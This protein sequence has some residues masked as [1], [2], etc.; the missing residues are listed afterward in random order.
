M[1]LVAG[2]EHK[3]LVVSFSL[4][5]EFS[6]SVDEFIKFKLFDHQ[7]KSAEG[8]KASQLVALGHF[9]VLPSVEITLIFHVNR[10]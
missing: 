9:D 2:L 7:E 3:D 8:F 5:F 1:D 4:A 6:H 10:K